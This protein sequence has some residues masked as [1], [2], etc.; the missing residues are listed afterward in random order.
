MSVSVA[1]V[2]YAMDISY[3]P[4]SKSAWGFALFTHTLSGPGLKKIKGYTCISLRAGRSGVRI[5]MGAR[6]STP[7]Q[8]CAAVYPATVS[9]PRIKRTEC[10]VNHSLPSS[11]EVK[12]RVELYPPPLGL[13]A[14]LQSEICLM[15][16][17]IGL[18]LS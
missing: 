8:T 4:W 3:F 14:L 17:Y 11:V 5:W 6:F 10:G 2:N 7:V 13:C 12:E 9:F 15:L 18:W 16:H 1:G